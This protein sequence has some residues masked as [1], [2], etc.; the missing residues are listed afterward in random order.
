MGGVGEGGLEGVVEDESPA[1]PLYVSW[2]PDAQVGHAVHALHGR[3]SGRGREGRGG[4]NSH[5]SYSGDSAAA[6]AAAVIFIV[7]GLSAECPSRACT[8][9][10]ARTKQWEREGRQ[11]IIEFI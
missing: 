7:R 5:G 2:Q 11:R 9:C 1:S 6:T 10:P 4:E 8:A 3:S